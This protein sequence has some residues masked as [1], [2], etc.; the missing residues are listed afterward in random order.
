ML[1][2]C[3]L[4]PKVLLPRC[5]KPPYFPRREKSLLPK[6]L[7]QLGPL[8]YVHQIL[9]ELC[10]I[11]I[12]LNFFFVI[13]LTVYIQSTELY[14][15]QFMWYLHLTTCHGRTMPCLR[16]SCYES[17][18]PFFKLHFFQNACVWVRMAP[19][20]GHLCHIDTF[21]VHSRFI[22]NIIISN[23]KNNF[24]KK[25]HCVTSIIKDSWIVPVSA[26]LN[27]HIGYSELIIFPIE[28]HTPFSLYLA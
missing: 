3:V 8:G 16:S 26:V 2:S 11:E 24:K 21:L 12:F 4:R 9:A 6:F 22:K 15:S 14:R 13:P 5:S 27:K 23:G 19:G 25:Y 17:N 18:G 7:G 1:L 28:L 10:P 20:R